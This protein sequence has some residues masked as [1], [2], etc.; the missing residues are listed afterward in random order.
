MHAAE[1]ILTVMQERIEANSIYQ[2]PVVKTDTGQHRFVVL[3]LKFACYASVLNSNRD[4]K[5]VV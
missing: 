2:Q 5:S 1:H 3:S 4:R